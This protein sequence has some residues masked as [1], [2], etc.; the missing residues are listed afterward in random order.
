V[1]H[2]FHTQILDAAYALFLERGIA[3]T[4]MAERACVSKMTVYANF[5]DKPT[6]LSAV[7][8]RRAKTMHLPELPVGSDLWWSAPAS[9]RAWQPCVT[10]PVA[11]K[12]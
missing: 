7:F 3:A 4:P 1:D 8:E 10:P 9:T 6:L 12:W 2:Q 11:A 5:R